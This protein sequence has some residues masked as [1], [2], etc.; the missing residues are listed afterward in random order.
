MILSIAFGGFMTTTHKWKGKTDRKEV[1]KDLKAE[2]DNLLKLA[3]DA[4]DELGHFDNVDSSELTH[5][6]DNKVDKGFDW[7]Q[8]P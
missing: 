5:Q 4:L 8:I 3:T 6:K 7:Y 1:I 2:V